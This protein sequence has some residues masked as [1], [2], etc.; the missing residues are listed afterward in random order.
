M[1][2]TAPEP[3]VARYSAEDLTL[4][5]AEE[6][7][8]FLDPLGGEG[9][10]ALDGDAEAWS[11][12]A[13]HLAWD[14][15][16]RKEPHLYERLIAGE[17]VHPE[18]VD[19]LPS[20]VQS[21]V[22]VGAGTG[23]LTLAIAGR[24][25]HLVA[26]EPAASLRELLEAKLLHARLFN[27]D[28]RRGFFDEIP[29]ESGR[30]DLVVSCSALTSDPRQGGDPGLAEMERVAAPGGLI[31]VVW[32]ADVDWLRANGFAYESFPGPMYV[33][34]TD[35]AE[36]AEVASVFYPNAL[37]EIVRRGLARVP[38]DLLGMNPPRDVAWKRV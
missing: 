15:L 24:C 14:L 25:R 35:A 17:R 30:A 27:V 12:I 1:L 18:V 22:E 8:R 16:Y 20:S 11:R 38:Y 21:A 23:R 10:A 19:W 34:F 5:D 9:R 37:D 36:A 26:V 4:F 13:P 6:R 7:T 33:E 3:L 28:V 2:T 32:P 29:V 31:A